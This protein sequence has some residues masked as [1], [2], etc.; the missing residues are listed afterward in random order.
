MKLTTACRLTI[1]T[2]I[3]M[4]LTACPIPIPK[5]DL[6]DSRQNLGDSVPEFIVVGKTTR[7][8]ILMALG[9]PDGASEHSEWFVYLRTASTGGVVFVVAAGGGMGGVSFEGMTARRLLIY[10]DTDG[11]VKRAA[12]DT[13][14]CSANSVLVGSSTTAAHQTD[15]CT[16]K[17]PGDA[18]TQELWANATLDDERPYQVFASTW[19]HPGVRGFERI[20]AL[21]PETPP[22][23]GTLVVGARS[24]RFVLPESDSK[25]DPLIKVDY[26]AI[27][28]VFVDKFGRGRRVVIQRLSGTFESFSISGGVATDSEATEKTG[29]L[30]KARWQET[31]VK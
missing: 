27:A 28:D 17:S 16:R 14:A 13:V 29:E 21:Q 3:S 12:H 20:R 22:T 5:G 4:I 25:S 23:K 10:F 9:E 15:P 7:A 11:V 30:I 31:T 26:P 24:L 19:W 2:L 8:E 18:P 6:S 1:I